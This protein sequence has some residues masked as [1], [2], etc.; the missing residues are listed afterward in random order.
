VQGNWA[1]RQQA[2]Q[3]A[4]QA[5]AEANFAALPLVQHLMQNLGGK[6]LPGSVQLAP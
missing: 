6:I 1:Q 3:S 2:V 5:T 4:Q